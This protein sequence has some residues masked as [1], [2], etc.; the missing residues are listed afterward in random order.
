MTTASRKWLFRLAAMFLVPALMLGAL[1]VVLRLA[2]HGY[3]PRLFK[4]LLV[5]GQQFLVENDKFSLRFFPPELMRT[6]GPI[7]MQPRKPVNTYR[8]FILGESA[9]MGDPE[10]GFGAGR[11]LEVLLR[12]RFP[13]AKIEVINVAFT[14]INSHVILP[15]ARECAVHEG[16]LWIIYMG[17]NEMVGP[18][19][20][21]TVFG[22]KAPPL[23]LV[24]ASLA[25]QKTR[26]GQLLASLTDRLKA[27]SSTPPS[28]GGMQMFL[29][30]QVPPNAASKETVY[31]NFQ[32]N[33]QGILR[34][35]RDSGVAILLSTV[36]VNL[37][38]CP[39]LASIASSNLPAS[40]RILLEQLLVDGR[41]FEGQ[42]NFAAAARCYEQATALDPLSAELQYR[43]GRSLLELTNV[44]AAR[45]HLQSACDLDALPFRAD[46]RVNNLIRQ[47]A[48]E[49]GGPALIPFEAADWLTT[50]SPVG[51]P[52]SE[53]LYEHVHLN[54]DGNYRLALG[55]A[56]RTAALL[57]AT[58]TRGAATT[59][60]SQS[61]CEH[62]LGLTDWN[63]CIVVEGM[64]RRMQQPPLGAQANNGQRQE[65]LRAW[66][67][68]MHGRMDAASA[69]K[70]REGFQAALKRTPDDYCL[71]E[72]FA[73]F[74]VATGDVPG[75]VA[76][77]QRIHE[78]I[79][80]DY[81][82]TYR[83]GD[84]L[85]RQGRWAEAQ[86]ALL[87]AS[88]LRP[89]MSDPWFELGKIHAAEGKLEL[90]LPKFTRARELRPSDAE[91][92]Y[93]TGRTLALL[94]RRAEAIEQFRQAV[95][96]QPGYWQAHDA[97]GGQLGLDGN[98]SEAKAEF[99]EVVRLK[100]DYAPAHLNLGV[101]LLKQ[102]Q[103]AAAAAE[104]EKALRLEP[105]NSVARDYL[106][107][108][109]AASVKP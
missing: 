84:L 9:A 20:A 17:N 42:R 54:F 14:A 73:T 108:A 1:E 31:R 16:D 83:L 26:L 32:S 12:A 60:L 40:D 106:R 97:V 109:Q 55:W 89:F 33:L 13:E 91:Y 102:G 61:D 94:N 29:G 18:F 99:A 24:R 53:V 76:Q 86:A 81:L 41:A 95:R 43:W 52:G 57:P 34:A 2:G 59:W 71:R 105:T 87:Q 93:H 90:A 3:S 49:F 47:A 67:N 35:G 98:L 25:V 30:N 64:I 82:A 77:W 100:P 7:R 51:I 50:N 104:F 38:D 65:S 21:A 4:P 15:I 23:S 62:G 107:Q 96:L 46:S 28:W 88:A 75:A 36:A 27:K 80:Q 92:A 103:A 22:P 10:P 101:A 11:Y 85:A 66:L 72:N 5:G 70:A 44:A 74:L 8:I 39:P 69:A 78:L 48:H 79:P 37:T 58:M 45:E 6:P 63:R 68:E 56:E 19:G